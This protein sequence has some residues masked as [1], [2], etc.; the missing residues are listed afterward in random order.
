[1][2]TNNEDSKKQIK[3]ATLQTTAL[4]IIKYLGINLT[5]EVKICNDENS[6]MF[7]KEIKA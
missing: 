6:K 2:H 4:Q 7:L 5:K 3:K 1:M